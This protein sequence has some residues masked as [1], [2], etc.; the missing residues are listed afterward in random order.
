MKRSGGCG[1][2][3][4]SA[5]HERRGSCVGDGDEPPGA[6]RP[7]AR[8]RGDRDRGRRLRQAGRAGARAGAPCRGARSPR[9]LA[10][11][12]VPGSSATG[13]WRTGWRSGRLS[14][15]CWPATCSCSRPSSWSGSRDRVINVHPALLPAFPGVRP[16]EDALAYGVKVFGVTVHFVDGGV[17]SGPVILQ[18]ALEL[19]DA[20]D[21]DAV[22]ERLHPIEHELLPEAVRLIAAR[23][24]QLRPGQPAPC[25]DRA[26]ESEAV[27]ERGTEHLTR[28]EPVA[29]G[30]VQV[31][32]ALLSVS[33]KTGL[34]EFARGLAELGIEIVSTGGTARELTER[35]PAGPSDL[36]ADRLSRDH[37]RAGQDASPEALRRAAGPARRPRPHAPGRGERGRVRRS[38]VR[39]PVSRSSAPRL[40]VGWAT[41]R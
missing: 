35:R 28:F 29:A 34:V 26:I 16:V 2:F 39:E 4:S 30:E 17:D 27:M 11:G 7:G 31:A 13:R 8:P 32:R 37:G 18:R 1:R 10:S 22:L 25:R 21:P 3:R 9:S 6:A 36:R 38:G 5:R 20:R 40:A 41:P 14:S 24:G 33:D 23:S 19:P 15:W 12:S